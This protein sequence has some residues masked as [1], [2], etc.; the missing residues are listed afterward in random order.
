[1]TATEKARPLTDPG[2]TEPLPLQNSQAE[3]IALEEL[4]LADPIRDHLPASAPQR[5]VR[6]VLAILDQIQRE[7]LNRRFRD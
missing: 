7:N 3:E 5:K 2:V 6:G 1:M 4:R